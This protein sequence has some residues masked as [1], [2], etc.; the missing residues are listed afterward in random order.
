[1]PDV[2]MTPLA[3]AEALA[4]LE[5]EQ[6]SKALSFLATAIFDQRVMSVMQL[7]ERDPTLTQ[8]VLSINTGFG[9]MRKREEMDFAQACL[10]HHIAPGYLRAIRFGY[11]PSKLLGP[12]LLKLSRDGNGAETDIGL[13]LAAGANPNFACKEFPGGIFSAA[14][15]LAYP[16]GKAPRAPGLIIMLLDAKAVPQVAADSPGPLHVIISSDWGDLAHASRN[17][18]VMQRLVAAGIGINAPAGPMQTTPLVH[19]VGSK[20][21]AAVVALIR[22]GCSI[23][24]ANLSGRKDL[25]E[26]LDLNG[27]ADAKP[28][29]QQAL[30]ER[31][32]AAAT[33]AAG[34]ADTATAAPGARRQQRVL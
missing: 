21:V 6:R 5:G 15:S 22:M 20:N 16:A 10:R 13:I 3:R 19:A 1:M 24:P 31:E 28:M 8:E 9:N 18:Q 11:D 29:V 34:R 32:I 7:V 33:A 26:L 12:A 23:E 17:L 2:L 30:M 27:Q 25:Y 14:M 4:P